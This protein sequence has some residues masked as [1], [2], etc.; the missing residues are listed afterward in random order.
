MDLPVSFYWAE[1]KATYIDPI[2]NTLVHELY[3]GKYGNQSL[4]E[5]RTGLALHV[6]NKINRTHGCDEYHGIIPTEP[7]IALVERGHCYFTDKIRIATKKYKASAVV[8]YN[9]A[10]RGI[11]VMQH[12]GK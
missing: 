5:S 9:D 12:A 1:V 6:R 3:D 11:V 2:T 8:I 4:V 7:W 10:D